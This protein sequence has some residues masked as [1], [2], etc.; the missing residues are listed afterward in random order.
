M[1][2][3]DLGSPQTD[4]TPIARSAEL[5]PQLEMSYQRGIITVAIF[6]TTNCVRRNQLRMGFSAPTTHHGLR[7]ELVPLLNQPET[8]R[9]VYQHIEFDDLAGGR[10]FSPQSARNSLADAIVGVGEEREVNL[11]VLD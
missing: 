11:L 6:V 1:V 7:V 5:L 2:E 4:H 10:L 8:I 3:T 9:A